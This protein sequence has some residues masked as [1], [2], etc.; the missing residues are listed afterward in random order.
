MNRKHPTC[1]DMEAKPG[2]I[3]FLVKP[4]G[5]HLFGA[6]KV[7]GMESFA[8]LS[9]EKLGQLVDIVYA[10]RDE[11]AT[12]LEDRPGFS[13]LETHEC[14]ACHDFEEFYGLEGPSLFQYQSRAWLT[15]VVKDAGQDFLYDDQNTMPRFGDRLSKSD[16]DAVV[17]FLQTLENRGDK[18]AWPFSGAP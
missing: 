16:I 5:P 11:K 10:Q 13:L 2:S 1:P 17:A 4:D 14:S 12:P 7:S 15:E 8:Q 6:T 3:R 18:N 9:P